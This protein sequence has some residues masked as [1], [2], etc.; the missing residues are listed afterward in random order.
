M[1][2]RNGDAAHTKVVQVDR[3]LFLFR[4]SGS[5]A[6]VAPTITVACVPGSERKIALLSPPGFAAG[7]LVR[8][9]DAFVLQAHEAARLSVHVRPSAPNGSVEA[10]VSIERL[11]HVAEGDAG[12][13]RSDERRHILGGPGVLEL[14]AHVAH[15]GDIH[16]PAGQWIA[17][18]ESPAQIE[19]LAV[20]SRGSSV[21]L[22][23]KYAVRIGGRSSTLMRANGEG[24][25]VGTRGQARPLTEVRFELAGREARNHELAIEALFQDAA[26]VSAE[27]RSVAL[28]G[29]S[30]REA[31]L[32]LRVEL[33]NLSSRAAAASQNRLDDPPSPHNGVSDPSRGRVRV[34]RSSPE[35]RHRIN[36]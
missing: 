36:Q 15:V 32:G 7:T 33:L 20:S 29:P 1:P 3:G 25:F 26:P 16:V 19:G 28:S 35:P 23:L 4:Y 2:I 31:L 5:A 18:P 12:A 21:D 17:G 6:R 24:S 30:G 10:D 14:L 27:G 22:G 11:G 34:F 8:P 13:Q 9:G